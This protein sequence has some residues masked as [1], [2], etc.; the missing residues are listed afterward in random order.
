MSTNAIEPSD[1]LSRLDVPMTP[2]AAQSVLQ[3]KF[4]DQAI[5]RMNELAEKARRGT[6]SL[7]EQAAIEMFERVNNVLGI[8]KSRAR[9]LLST[10][11]PASK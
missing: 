8:L 4:T 3:W 7:D 11:D 10:S 2:A 6:L 1:I 9:Q 5:D